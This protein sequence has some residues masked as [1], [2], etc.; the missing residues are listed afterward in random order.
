M[1]SSNLISYGFYI[2]KIGVWCHCETIYTL[3]SLV[4]VDE[5]CNMHTLHCF[6]VLVIMDLHMNKYVMF[7]HFTGYIVKTI[8]N[9]NHCLTII[10]I[11]HLSYNSTR[12]SD[13]RLEN[14][15]WIKTLN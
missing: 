1:V 4:T 6:T 11:C 13:F 15:D 7:C 9:L 12:Q 2:K 8:Y 3:Y 5:I 10:Y 14:S